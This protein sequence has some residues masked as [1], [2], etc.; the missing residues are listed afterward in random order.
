MME[1]GWRDDGERT[2]GG[3]RDDGERTEGGW[4]DDGERTEGG[5]RDD[6]VFGYLGRRSGRRAHCTTR[7]VATQRGGRG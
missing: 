5:W 1:R 6:L 4:R 3:W 2:E 7:Q